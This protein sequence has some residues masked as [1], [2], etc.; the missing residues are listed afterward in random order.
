MAS[1]PTA[2][3]PTGDALDSTILRLLMDTMP[4]HIYFKDRES[5]IVRNNA[6]HAKSMGV[7]SPD[8][9]VG[10]TDR[11]FFTEEHAAR[12]FVDEQIIMETGVP[13]IGII[14]RITRLNGTVFWGSATKMPWRDAE[15]R[16]IGTFGLTRD[17]TEL[18]NADDLLTGERNLLRTIIDHLPSR[19]F[20]KDAHSRYL[21]NNKAHIEYLGARNQEEMLGRTLEDFFPGPRGAQALADDKQVLE[22]GTPIV[23]SERSNFGT[24]GNVHWSLTTKVP[25]RDADGRITGIVGISHDITRRKLAEEELRRYSSEMEADVRMA[26]RVQEAF[27]PRTYPVFPSGVPEEASSIRFAHKYIPATTL[28]GDFVHI[29]PLSDSRCG[30]LICDVMGH[31]VRAG[32]LTA[33]IRGVVEEL[34]ERASDPAHVIS[35]INRGLIPIMEKT[36]ELVFATAAYAVVDTESCTL[37]YCNAGHPWP[38]VRRGGAGVVEALVNPDPDPAAGLIENFAYASATTSFEP[39]DCLFLYTDGLVEASNAQSAMY[40]EDRLKQFVGRDY[41]AAGSVLIDN[42]IGDIRAF[43]GRS[44]FEDDICAIA[45]ES[46]GNVCAL[47]TAQTFE[48]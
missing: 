15:G 31:G 9:C 4:D 12:A 21:L 48:V 30:I 13:V 40:G 28:G 27:L 42:L 43:T 25:L 34:E 2:P 29:L 1:T 46:T 41:S 39:G 44:E 8:D 18:K 37:S 35:E 16:I 36:G 24:E 32:L 38:L 14:E 10:K 7:A 19:V 22:G 3:L 23:N 5:R 33:L 47:R 20:V 17:I 11:D 6:A 45:V 26:C